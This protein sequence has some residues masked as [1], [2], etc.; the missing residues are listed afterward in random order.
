MADTSAQPLEAVFCVVAGGNSI[1]NDA[2][3][4]EAF[5]EEMA[6]LVPGT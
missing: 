2:L 5:R 1:L 3:D 4:L 6:N